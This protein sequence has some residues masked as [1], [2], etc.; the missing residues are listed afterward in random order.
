MDYYRAADIF[1]LPSLIET[2]GIVILEAMAAGLAVVATDVPGCRDVVRDGRNGLLVPPR[3]SKALAGAVKK[4][5]DDSA[6]RKKL[7]TS[8]AESSCERSW[9]KVAESYADLFAELVG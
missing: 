4:L 2:L 3:D 1:V 6:L 5:V 8:A 9:G 7:T